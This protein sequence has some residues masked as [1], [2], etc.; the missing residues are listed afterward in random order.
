M[1]H[2]LSVFAIPHPDYGGDNLEQQRKRVEK[3]FSNPYLVLTGVKLTG[4]PN[5]LDIVGDGPGDWVL[6]ENFRGIAD[7]V[8]II[9]ALIAADPDHPCLSALEIHAHANPGQ[10]DS[11]WRSNVATE[12]A[13]LRRAKWCDNGSIYLAGC[14]T[15]LTDASYI[16][17]PNRGS[18]AKRLATALK[19]TPGSF[20][21][22]ITVYGSAGFLTGTHFDKSAKIVASPTRDGVDVPP[23]EGARDAAKEAD[24]WNAFPNW[25]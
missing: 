15:G 8:N 20:E 24:C 11:L 13:R 14:N 1:A 5:A 4:G 7:L 2:T 10:C 19:Y 17:V 3:L 6:V 25:P 23:Y 16:E 18:L 21:N 22:H 9:R 12:G